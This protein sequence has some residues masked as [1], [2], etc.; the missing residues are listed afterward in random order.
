MT[1]FASFA[2]TIVAALACSVALAAAGAVVGN[3]HS[4]LGTFLVTSSGRTLYLF[5][6][7]PRNHTTCSGPCAG[8]WP[9]LTTAGTPKASGAV[10]QALLGTIKRG[11]TEQVTYAG[12]A[13]YTYSGD[14]RPGDTNSQN[15]KLFGAKWFVVGL[16]GAAI[17]KASG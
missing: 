13:L 12:H 10:K 2:A 15:L 9:P 11:S 14:M 17:T 7:D 8:T 16:G 4:S 6:A 5:A 3:R 1:R